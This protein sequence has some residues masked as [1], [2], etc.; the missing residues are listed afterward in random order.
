MKFFYSFLIC[1]LF[2]HYSFGQQP[3]VIADTFLFATKNP[4]RNLKTLI[5]RSDSTYL[6]REKGFE[7]LSLS[8]GFWS[9][10]KDVFSLSG[11]FNSAVVA[12][13]EKSN[14][15][16]IDD[17]LVTFKVV[18]CYGNL[19]PNYYFIFFDK[20]LFPDTS[21]TTNNITNELGI[22]VVNKNKFTFYTTE[23]DEANTDDNIGLWNDIFYRPISPNAKTIVVTLSFPKYFVKESI[24]NNNLYMFRLR[25]FRLKGKELLDI[26]N[27]NKFIRK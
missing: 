18:D 1:T 14:Y 24:D 11:L 17:S 7:H 12:K 21:Y 8:M 19:I 16:T 13:T 23:T 5:L 26:E 9:K 3:K 27:G 22:L 2:T 20:N 15:Y 6:L 4:F 25:K 10:K